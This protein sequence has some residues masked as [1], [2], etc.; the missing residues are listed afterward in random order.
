MSDA[1]KGNKHMKTLT[2][3]IHTTLAAFGCFAL[4]Q[5]AQALNP[6]PDG[7]YPGQNTAEGTLALF[8]LTTGAGNT[9]L[10]YRAL[11]SNTSGFNNTATGLNALAGSVDGV[12][13]VA[14]GVAALGSNASGSANTAVGNYALGLLG[15]NGTSQNGNT[16][17]GFSAL[18][19][20]QNQE[21]ADNNTAV[22]AFALGNAFKGAFNIAL[23]F[24]AGSSL[25]VG[26]NNIYIG[27][28]GGNES[29]TIRIGEE[30]TRFF[31][32]GIGVTQ[33]A[34]FIAGISGVAVT[35]V[36]VRVS[37]SG[38]LGVAPSSERFKDKIKPMDKASEAILALKP[39]SFRY[40]K[41]IDPDRTTQF[42]LV[43]EDVAKVDPD[44]IT[45]DEQGRPETVRYDAVNAMLLNEFLKEHRRVQEL[46]STVA[47]D[48]PM[49]SQL[50]STVAKQETAGA[51]Q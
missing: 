12:E 48:E 26:H 37:S 46:K 51:E 5:T 45:R 32:A 49:I 33:T 28:P 29:D 7:G 10:G 19:L 15:V 4:S 44:L 11:Y 6:P 21:E 40:K 13:N 18:Q 23:G 27:N 47:K 42:G 2:N 24:G 17:V 14:N 8:S 9:A 3:I 39:V 20:L 43:A 36:P 50:K 35:G 38:Q 41:E 31:A 22:G 25:E 1:T 16:A 34:T 30:Q